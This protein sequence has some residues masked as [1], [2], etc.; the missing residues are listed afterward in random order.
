MK[1][2]VQ[3][4]SANC[5]FL[6][7]WQIEGNYTCSNPKPIKW[8]QPPAGWTALN[9]N[10][11]VLGEGIGGY[12]AIGRDD[13]GRAV[14][15]IA[16]ATLEHNILRMELMAIKTGLMK[17]SC[18]GLSQ[19]QVRSDSLSAVQSISGRYKVPWYL[20]ELVEEILTLRN[21]FRSC[22]FVHHVREIN[23]CADF[24]VGF[25]TS[26]QEIHLCTTSLPP[27]LSR[28]IREDAAGKTYYR[29]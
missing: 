8:P 1:T 9:C 28:I 2:S 6:Y 19:I 22:V 20:R 23:S 11:L 29:M 17:A 15:G 18:L 25:L 5:D 12:G 7:R 24:L 3:D 4:S 21:C 27:A 14:F 13:T 10:G 26:C 16:G